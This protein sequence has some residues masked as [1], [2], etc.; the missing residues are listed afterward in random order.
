MATKLLQWIERADFTTADLDSN[1]GYLSTQ[2][3]RAFLRDAVEATAILSRADNFDS[4]SKLFEIPKISFSDRIMYGGTEFTRTVSGSRT[5]PTTAL[6]TLT[7]QLFRGEI[8]VSDEMFEDNVEQSGLANSLMQLIAEAVGRDLEEIAIKSD[9]D[10]ADTSFNLFDGIVQSLVDANQNI[11]DAA[12]AASYVEILDGMIAKLP[13]RYR[14]NW[15]SL[16]C[17]VPVSMRDGYEQ[18]IGARATNLGDSYV[19]DRQE[20]RYRSIPLV[21]VPL[22]TGTQNT[23]DYSKFAILCDPQNLKVGWHRRVRV[24]KFRD[25][26]EG[27]MSFVP[28]CRYDV[29]WAE[30]KAVVLGKNIPAL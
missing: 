22:L 1:G 10:D 11:Y 21:E 3:A 8:P 13:S 12:A 24:E 26:R 16:V 25:P 18:E 30:N 6:V 29:Q 9:T 27:G 5:S 20:P 4:A 19:G 23:V 28:S 17:F 15:A 7:T 14:R 2:Q